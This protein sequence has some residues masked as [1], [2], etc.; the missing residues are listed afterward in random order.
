MDCILTTSKYKELY[1]VE[2]KRRKATTTT[3]IGEEENMPD[4][5]LSNVFLVLIRRIFRKWSRSRTNIF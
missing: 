3:M 2:K 4:R 5:L 1:M